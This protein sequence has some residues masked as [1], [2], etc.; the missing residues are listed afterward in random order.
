MFQQKVCE[1]DFMNVVKSTFVIFNFHKLFIFKLGRRKYMDSNETKVQNPSPIQINLQIN[2]EDE[3]IISIS[4]IK[5]I[6]LK[7]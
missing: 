7:I 1:I 4:D 5:E 3:Y 6:S 2:T